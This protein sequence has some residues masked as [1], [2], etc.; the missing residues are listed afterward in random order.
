MGVV[1]MTSQHTGHTNKESGL[2]L[3]ALFF[4]P[5]GVLSCHE[6]EQ[7]LL[8]FVADGGLVVIVVVLEEYGEHVG[9]GLALWVAHGEHRGVGTFGDEL[10]LQAV[11]LS[12]ASDDTANFPEANV[13]EELTAGDA[14]LA[15]E[16]LVDVV[17]GT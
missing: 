16:Q 6:I 12:V 2:W 10:V 9:Y 13:V 3:A 4:L 5:F 15:H 7:F 14:Y 1:A 11:A 8:V 17:G